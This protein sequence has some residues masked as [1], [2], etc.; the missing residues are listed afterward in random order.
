MIKKDI[1]AYHDI[2]SE[3]IADVLYGSTMILFLQ[4]LGKRYELHLDILGELTKLIELVLLGIEKA[5]N[6]DL[7]LKKI[8]PNLSEENRARL[9]KEINE[10]IFLPIREN[11]INQYEKAKALERSAPPAMTEKR[12]LAPSATDTLNELEGHLEAGIS[13]LKEL[14]A[15]AP[16]MA[17]LPSEIKV[18]ET[19]KITIAPTKE[20]PSNQPSQSVKENSPQNQPIPTEKTGYVVDPYRE[21]PI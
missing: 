12:E 9:L 20:T 15:V 17:P 14:K 3:E 18:S 16:K 4:D 5:E 21:P 7:Q 6:F 8:T 2:L 11:L 13:D 19:E 1:L 10:K